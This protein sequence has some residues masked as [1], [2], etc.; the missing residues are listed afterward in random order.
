MGSEAA[1]PPSRPVR[2]PQDRRESVLPRFYPVELLIVIAIVSILAAMLLPVLAQALRVARMVSCQ[3]NLKQ[4][5]LLLVMYEDDFGRRLPI[6]NPAGNQRSHLLRNPFRG[7]CY[8]GLGMLL[9]KPYDCGKRLL[10]CPGRSQH[11]G[12]LLRSDDCLYGD[13]AVGWYACNDWPND[14]LRLKRRDGS[15][16][17]APDSA[18]STASNFS[19]TREQ[20]QYE[21]TGRSMSMWGCMAMVADARGDGWDSAWG[22]VPDATDIPHGNAACA[23]TPLGTTKAVER[24]FD[25]FARTTLP[26]QW[27]DYLWWVGM[28]QQLRKK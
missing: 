5:N 20:F 2:D 28:D 26:H 10:M 9:K 15:I 8:E 23:L 16:Y 18:W 25:G 7:L 11:G 22:A 21:W 4:I 1:A 14:A 17:L 19:P 3:S 27:P 24:A 13:Y 12:G 6:F